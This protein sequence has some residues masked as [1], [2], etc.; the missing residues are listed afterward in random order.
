MFPAASVAGATRPSITLR[1][2]IQDAGRHT[3]VVLVLVSNV[4]LI[5][6]AI[7]DMAIDKEI[8]APPVPQRKPGPRLRSVGFHVVAI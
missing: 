6:S 3:R 1:F 4:V 8:G 2:P 5:V 7:G